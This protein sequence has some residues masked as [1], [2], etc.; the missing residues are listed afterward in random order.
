MQLRTLHLRK[1]VAGVIHHPPVLT[2]EFLLATAAH[3]V[4]RGVQCLL[5][6]CRRNIRKH[7][8]PNKTLVGAA[9]QSHLSVTKALREVN[10][11][12]GVEAID[13]VGA[14]VEGDRAARHGI[15]GDRHR[16]V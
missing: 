16:F 3:C 9:N 2:N 8:K 7:R 11:L 1:R 4:D 10:N 12:P 15:H 5:G 13:V 6:G 14:S